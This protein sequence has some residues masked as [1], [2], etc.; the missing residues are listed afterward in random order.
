MRRLA[1]HAPGKLAN[2]LEPDLFCLCSDAHFHFLLIPLFFIFLDLVYII[3]LHLSKKFP[4]II[5]FI[6]DEKAV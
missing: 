2:Y 1:V 3:A 6:G 4:S 5:V